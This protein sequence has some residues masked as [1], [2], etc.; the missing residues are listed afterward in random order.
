MK[1]HNTHNIPLTPSQVSIEPP[2]FAVVY[3]LSHVVGGVTIPQLEIDSIWN[4][5]GDAMSRLDKIKK[6]NQEA[7]DNGDINSYTKL[8][9]IY[10]E[11]HVLDRIG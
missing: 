8:E 1:I 11:E 5:K 7:F 6:E 4:R 3:I 2:V 9:K 10:I